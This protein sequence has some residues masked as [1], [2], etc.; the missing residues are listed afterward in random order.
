MLREAIAALNCRAPD[1][2]C[3]YDAVL[4]FG[5]SSER[6][7]IPD[8]TSVSEYCASAAPERTPERGAIRSWNA[9]FKCDALSK[10]NAV[11]CNDSTSKCDTVP[12]HDAI[13]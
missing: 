4:E 6:F 13:Y 9:L 11:S 1:A 7:A 10:H 8:C 12:D 3:E 2:V 5:T